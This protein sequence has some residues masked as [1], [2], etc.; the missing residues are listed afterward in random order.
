MKKTM[1]TL[2]AA[3]L[4]ATSV[5]GQDNKKQEPKQE[6]KKEEKKSGGTRM[7][8]NEKGL[9]GT[10][11]KKETTNNNKSESKGTTNSSPPVEK[12]EDPKK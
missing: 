11:M 10:G 4:M 12:K 7:A 2:S 6:P 5:F 8:I 1:I 9:P 3:F